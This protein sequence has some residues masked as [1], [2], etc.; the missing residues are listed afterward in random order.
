ML[1]MSRISKQL[2]RGA[3]TGPARSLV[4]AFSAMLID[5]SL[6]PGSKCTER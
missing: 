1:D 4:E 5:Q 3:L 2:T 6:D